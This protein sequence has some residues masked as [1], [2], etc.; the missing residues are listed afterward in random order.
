MAQNNRPT[1][2]IEKIS[3]NWIS[4]HADGW[5]LEL[6]R[7]EN[8]AQFFS[9]LRNPAGD[10]STTEINKEQVSEIIDRFLVRHLHMA[11]FY[12]QQTTFAI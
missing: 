1:V 7:A 9:R 4:L 12:N 2:R 6:T 3:S 8:G 10:W 11:D 5:T